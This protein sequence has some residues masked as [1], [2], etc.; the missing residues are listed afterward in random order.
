MKNRILIAT[1]ASLLFASC[2]HENKNI[3]II[4]S[5]ADDSIFKE[6]HLAPYCSMANYFAQ[7]FD[8]GFIFSG[9]STFSWKIDTVECRTIFCHSDAYFWTSIFVTPGDSVSFKTVNKGDYFDVIF[10]GKNAA[11]YNYELEK[12]NAIQL[13]EPHPTPNIDQYEYK[14][15]LQ[16]YR[17]EEEKF[18]EKYKKQNKVTSEFVDYASAEINNK[19]VLSL[20][21]YVYSNKCKVDVEKFLEG[22]DIVQ[23]ALSHSAIDALLY[24]YVM[25]ASNSDI[26]KNFN[27]IQTEVIPQFRPTL[28][29][30]LVIWFAK[31]GDTSYKSALLNVI[32]QIETTSKDSMLLAN[33]KE[34]KS[35]YSLTGTALPDSVLNNTRLICYQDNKE[36]TLRQLLKTYENSAIYLD[37]WA[38]WC[39]PCRMTNSQSKDNKHELK[40]KGIV[41]AYIS[42]DENTEMWKKAAKE[43]EVVENQYC[44]LDVNSS[45][46]RNYFKIM[47]IPHFVLFNKK[48]EIVL[49]NAPRPIDCSFFEL[50]AIV[51]KL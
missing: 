24:K 49:L 51:E 33:V 41:V 17:A 44:L 11:H 35:F 36:I 19:Y 39:G 1:F 40:D 38:S 28:T 47:S 5:E 37:F 25:C 22:T 13:E 29:A 23:N 46:L 6:I 10:E 48:H 12:R 3:A 2:T 45:P 20:Y 14:K 50:K 16:A 30:N 21:D 8:E 4:R 43:D 26:E 42:M 9:D 18:L 15:Q 27:A 34:Y 7:S 31:K 32:N